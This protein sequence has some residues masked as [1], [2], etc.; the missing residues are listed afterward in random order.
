M[1]EMQPYRLDRELL[2]NIP[3]NKVKVTSDPAYKEITAGL[4]KGILE[5]LRNPGRHGLGTCCI[6]GCCVS[7]CCIQIV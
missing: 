7:W 5:I 1:P 3:T 4:Q 6:E 2:E